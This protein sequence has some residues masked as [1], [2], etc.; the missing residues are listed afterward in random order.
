MCPAL[1]LAVSSL[2][3]HPALQSVSPAVKC[4]PPMPANNEWH[5]YLRLVC[6]TYNELLSPAEQWGPFIFL[7]LTAR[8]KI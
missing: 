8:R 1:L 4:V 6:P 3:F 2:D 5:C 7:L